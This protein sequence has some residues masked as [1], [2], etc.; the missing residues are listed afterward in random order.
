MHVHNKINVT[1]LSIQSTS[2]FHIFYVMPTEFKRL[3]LWNISTYIQFYFSRTGEKKYLLNINEVIFL[4]QNQSFM[5]ISNKIN[6]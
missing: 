1:D 2:K 3:I 5:K 6:M 4:C